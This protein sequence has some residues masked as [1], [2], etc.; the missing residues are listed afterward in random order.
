MFSERRIRFELGRAVL[1][2]LGIWKVTCRWITILGCV[3][4]PL[5]VHASDDDEALK[6]VVWA[7]NDSGPCKRTALCATYIN[8]VGISFKDGDL[9]IAVK[10]QRLTTSAHDCIANAKEAKRKGNRALAV[11]WVMASQIHNEPVKRWLRDHG[12][13]VLAA[14]DR[15]N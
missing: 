12:D 6:H 3:L 2:F 7:W 8:H 10:I 14:L 9:G 13:A 1:R 15:V 11:E 4:S 5:S